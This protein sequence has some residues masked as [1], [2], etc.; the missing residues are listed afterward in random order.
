MVSIK[1]NRKLPNQKLNLL[2]TQFYLIKDKIK[3]HRYYL[4]ENWRSPWLLHINKKKCIMDDSKQNQAPV[5]SFAMASFESNLSCCPCGI[6]TK[7]I[8]NYKQVSLNKLCHHVVTLCPC[9]TLQLIL[10]SYDADCSKSLRQ[11]D[12][13]IYKRF[14]QRYFSLLIYS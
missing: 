2:L 8:P 9:N 10:Y 12:E 11:L 3:D 4:S 1:Y 6:K 14:V 13:R 7:P 5:L